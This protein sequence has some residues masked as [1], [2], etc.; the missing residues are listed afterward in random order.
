MGRKKREKTR[1]T[2][3]NS[4][5]IIALAIV[6]IFLIIGVS[7][8]YVNFLQKGTVS[9]ILKLPSYAYTNPVVLKAYK[10]AATHPDILEQ[11]SCYCG[12]GSHSGHRFLR[13]CF[14]DDNRNYDSHAS[15]CDVCIGEANKVQY[16]LSQGLT[17]R[18][19]RAEIDKEY[20]A[21]G[22]GTNTPQVSDDYKPI[23]TP[24]VA[25]ITPAIA[26]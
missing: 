15:F 12:C 7:A 5:K 18:E 8:I 20:G 16:Y 3:K 19:V 17:I 2:T 13:D 24:L 23:L 21:K 11:I 10:Y 1:K 14:L 26:R 4:S 9:T 6:G 25:S 22:G